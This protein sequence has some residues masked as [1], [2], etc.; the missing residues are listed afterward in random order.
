MSNMKTELNVIPHDIKP[1]R[2][3]DVQ[4]YRCMN[5]HLHTCLSHLSNLMMANIESAMNNMSAAA[6]P[7]DIGNFHM[8]YQVF[9]TAYKFAIDHNDPPQSSH[10]YGYAVLLPTLTEIM[11]MPNVKSKTVNQFVFRLCHI[12][13]STDAAKVGG[14][15]DVQSAKT[16]NEQIVIVEEAILLWMGKGTDNSDVGVQVPLFK[17]LGVVEPDF[18]FD[19]SSTHEPGPDRPITGMPDVPDIL[20]SGK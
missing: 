16:I 2:K 1:A 7:R 11:R 3:I 8:G 13:L 9:K 19:K 5:F 18:D 20:N 6:V 15:I 4:E 10:E 17:H 12:I 14:N